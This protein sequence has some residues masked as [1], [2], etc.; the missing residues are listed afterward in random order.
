VKGLRS[1]LKSWGIEYNPV[2]LLL[3]LE[4]EIGVIETSYRSTT[5]RWWHVIDRR[6]LEN[7][8]GECGVSPH[9]DVGDPRARDYSDYNSMC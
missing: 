6:A 5:Q 1:R 7:A 9:G 3:K 8:L 2:P 4:K